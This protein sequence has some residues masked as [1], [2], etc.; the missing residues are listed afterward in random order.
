MK[1]ESQSVGL[2]HWMQRVLRECTAAS[3]DLAVDPVHDLR[4]ALRRCRSMADGVMAI[5]PDPAWR[6]MKRSGKQLFSSLGALRDLQVMEEW[7]GKLAPA[8]DLARAKLLQFLFQRE[9]SAKSDA[10]QALAQF[11]RKQ[12]KRWIAHLSPRAVRLKLG[13]VV[14]QHLALERWTEACALHRKAMRSPSPHAL[15]S[16]RIGIKRLR[17]VVENFLPE[18][19]ARWKE[20]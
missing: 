10:A 12:W 4:V 7:A 9:E 16:L 14:Y 19:H 3:Q 20:G 2:G 15:H 8:D 17:Y 18:H 13:S 11:D 1:P 5:D 6:E